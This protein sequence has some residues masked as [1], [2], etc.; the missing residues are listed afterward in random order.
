MNMKLSNCQLLLTKCMLVSEKTDTVVTQTR[1]AVVQIREYVDDKF[2]VVSGDMQQVRRNAD[3]ISKVNATLVE[4]QNKLA[5]GNSNTPQSADSGNA[6]VR[7]ITTEQQAASV[8]SVETNTSPS[9]NGVN[10]S[11]NSACHYSTGVVSQTIN[12]G[13]CSSVNVTSEMQSKSVDLS[14]LHYLHLPIAVNKYRCILFVI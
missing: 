6:I 2:R 1:E 9:T 12:S 5:S 10:V 11:S 14:E 8:S 4:L 13:V 3:E 7:V